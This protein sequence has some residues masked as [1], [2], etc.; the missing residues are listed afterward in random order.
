MLSFFFKIPSNPLKK[1]YIVIILLQNKKELF[2]QKKSIY[3]DVCQCVIICIEQKIL[4]EKIKS[5]PVK[6]FK[7]LIN[8][9]TLKKKNKEK[10]RVKIFRNPSNFIL[11]T[12]K[13]KFK[14]LFTFL[15]DFYGLWIILWS[16]MTLINFATFENFRICYDDIA[17]FT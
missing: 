2:Q 6:C 4:F 8:F 7:S 17:F 3:T 13:N 11:M 12:F 10:K 9:W 5:I 15:N 1:S 14:K 16:L